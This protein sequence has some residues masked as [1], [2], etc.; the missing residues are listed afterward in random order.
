[1][2][3]LFFFLCLLFALSSVSFAEE[4]ISLELDMPDVLSDI[5]YVNQAEQSE[6]AI[7]SRAEEEPEYLST[8]LAGMTVP[9]ADAEN[10]SSIV[11]IIVRMTVSLIVVIFLAV[12]FLYIIKKFTPYG[13]TTDQRLIKVLDTAFIAAGKSIHVVDVAG[14]SLVIASDN[15]GI[16]FLTKLEAETSVRLSSPSAKSDFNKEIN[17][18]IKS[19][20]PALAL[21]KKTTAKQLN[22]SIQDSLGDIQQ[23]IAKLKKMKKNIG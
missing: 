8:E 10:T 17:E 21:Q 3:R 1:M 7:V 4:E 11:P 2:R 9:K 19:F 15:N 18:R 14:E 12:I 13:K 16:V 22:P 23:Q 6:V 20:D 5:E